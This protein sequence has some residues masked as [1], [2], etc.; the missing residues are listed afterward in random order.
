MLSQKIIIPKTNSLPFSNKTGLNVETLLD[1]I[2][3][4]IA[5]STVSVKL[6][7]PYNRGDLFN[8]LE[9]KGKIEIKDYREDGVYYEGEIEKKYY[10][11]VKEFDLEMMV[12]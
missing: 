1:L 11:K 12:S 2:V 8:I 10:D 7:I 6:L 3:N 4:E 5:P 9:Q